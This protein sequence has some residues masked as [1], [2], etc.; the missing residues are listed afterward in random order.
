ML[1]SLST[2]HAPENS[3]TPETS[4]SH[5]IRFELAIATLPR[6]VGEHRQR[7]RR[8]GPKPGGEPG[9]SSEPRAVS[10]CR[11]AGGT[12]V[13]QATTA[14]RAPWLGGALA[15]RRLGVMAC[16]AMCDGIRRHG[17]AARTVWRAA[18]PR[19]C[20]GGY[21]ARATNS[22]PNKDSRSTRESVVSQFE[23]SWGGLSG[24]R[25]RIPAGVGAAVSYGLSLVICEYRHEC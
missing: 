15:W 24:W 19:G 10:P 5:C 20:R 3:N 8:T 16:A 25:A 11:K 7:D 6:H 23:Y 13:R 14:G 4:R 21:D 18:P 12:R 17:I 9:I 1:G 2:L 22:Q